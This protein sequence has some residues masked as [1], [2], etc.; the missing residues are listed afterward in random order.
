MN[1]NSKEEIRERLKRTC[2]TFFINRGNSHVKAFVPKKAI[3]IARWSN[4]LHYLSFI[5]IFP[6]VIITF[7][8]VLL[9]PTI[10]FL[11]GICENLLVKWKRLIMSI[12]GFKRQLFLI[13]LDTRKREL[14]YLM[15]EY[16]AEGYEEELEV[17]EEL[18]NKHSN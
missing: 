3:N 12:S 7:I 1:A 17:I 4:F 16:G 8:L 9:H 15:K 13:N 10:E 18:K 5:F 14:Q 2:N 6:L 11:C